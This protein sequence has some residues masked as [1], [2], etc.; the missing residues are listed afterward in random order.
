[1]T[2][3]L[4]SWPSP[5]FVWSALPLSALD[6]VLSPVSSGCL[7]AVPGLSDTLLFYSAD[8]ASPLLALSVFS[9]PLPLG[10]AAAI[11]SGPVPAPAFPTLFPCASSLRRGRP[12]AFGGWRLLAA[13]SPGSAVSPARLVSWAVMRRRKRWSWGTRWMGGVKRAGGV[14]WGHAVGPRWRCLAGWQ[15]PVLSKEIG[16]IWRCEQDRG[17]A[18]KPQM[19]KTKILVKQAHL[20]AT[21][22]L[23]LQRPTIT[24]LIVVQ[25]HQSAS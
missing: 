24:H 17:K 23:S 21:E 4:W 12:A 9:V 13:V 1:M 19:C 3:F 20:V 16:F 18:A 25:I 22:H 2:F 14:R 11:P 15:Q 5:L 6:L 7:W 10:S 8:L